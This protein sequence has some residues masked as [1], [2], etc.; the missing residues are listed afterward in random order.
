MNSPL[1]CKRPTE[2]VRANHLNFDSL[3]LFSFFDCST[4]YELLLLLPLPMSTV[5]EFP[6][7]P[8]LLAGELPYPLPPSGDPH[9]I[10]DSQIVT[11]M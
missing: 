8:P 2:H 10:S 11:Q 5:V 9:P 6:L 3:P 4:F 7:T 1:R